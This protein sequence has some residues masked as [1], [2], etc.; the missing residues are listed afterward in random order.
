MKENPAPGIMLNTL[1]EFHHHN[2]VRWVLSVYRWGHWDPTRGSGRQQHMEVS[3][4]PTSVSFWLCENKG[5]RV[6]QGKFPWR[7]GDRDTVPNMLSNVHFSNI[8]LQAGLPC[9]FCYCCCWGWPKPFRV[10]RKRDSP[11]R[12]SLL[13]LFS[14]FSWMPGAAGVSELE[15]K[16]INTMYTWGHR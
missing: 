1:Q 7:G 3:R 15:P 12:L 6:S 2:L 11:L 16:Q 9:N 10:N 4:M 13:C 14:I 8:L 5:K